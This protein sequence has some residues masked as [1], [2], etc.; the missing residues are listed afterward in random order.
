MVCNSVFFVQSVEYSTLK[1]LSLAAE[2][3]R[4]CLEEERSLI[5]CFWT[6]ELP[7]PNEKGEFVNK[8]QLNEVIQKKK[9]MFI[10]ELGTMKNNVPRY[11]T[12]FSQV[13]WYVSRCTRSYI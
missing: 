10:L 7:A 12:V 4:I 11:I 3:M 6:S 1:E 9:N 2:N 5:S 8:K 13:T